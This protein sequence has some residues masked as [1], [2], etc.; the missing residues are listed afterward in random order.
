MRRAG[1]YLAILPCVIALAVSGAVLSAPQRPAKV[2]AEYR[3]DAILSF[4]KN[5][6]ASGEYYRAYGEIA[7]LRAL[8]PG[9]VEPARLHAT[10]LYL[11][12]MGERYSALRQMRPPVGR[13]IGVMDA[14]FRVDSYFAQRDYS[15]AD[16]LLRREK[17]IYGL[18][19]GTDESFVKRL[20]AADI[21]LARRDAMRE[22][23]DERLTAINGVDVS[24]YRELM[25]YSGE[26]LDALKSPAAAVACGIIP[27]MGYVYAD[28]TGTGV[29]ALIVV[30]VFST[31]TYFAFNTH[32]E[33]IGV[34]TGA[35]AGF[36]YG[37][38]ILGG[39]ME[40]KK[41]N[42]ELMESLLGTVSDELRFEYDRNELYRRHGIAP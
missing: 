42:R 29:L 7:R 31:L 4:T 30:T 17:S 5:L 22:I 8:H 14:L 23:A 32:N 35:I 37:G 27:G 2:P 13:D 34:F 36:F 16:A 38:S 20:I 11:L 10:E 1:R 9:A 39:Y 40:T 24:K 26:R 15:A 25:Q 33:H 41:Y 6:I 18:D 12:F 19:A 3:P 28:R 21:M